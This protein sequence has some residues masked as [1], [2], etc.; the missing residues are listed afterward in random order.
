MPAVPVVVTT[1]IIISVELTSLK[2]TVNTAAVP[3][4]TVTLLMVN[5][6]LGMTSV[7]VPVLVAV[8]LLV[9]P[10]VVVPVTVNVSLPSNTASTVVGTVAVPVKLPAG[11]VTGVVVV[12]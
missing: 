4:A 5:D 2:V 10:D 12:V 3:S 11:I 9:C 8:G 7:I 1:L 6:G